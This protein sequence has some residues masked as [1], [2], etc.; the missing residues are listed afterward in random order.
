M[1]FGAFAAVAGVDVDHVK[2]FGVL[3]DEIGPVLVSDGA[4][5]GGLDLAGDREIVENGDIALVELDDVF[6]FGG[7]ECDVVAHFFVDFPVVDV[8]AFKRGIEE[9]AKQS[10]GAAGLFVNERRL[11]GGVAVLNLGHGSIPTREE[12]AQFLVELC[13]SPSFGYG[14]NDD[15]ETFGLDAVH[16]LL[17]TC[18]LGIAFDFSGDADLVGEGDEDEITTRKG[19]F[20]GDARSLGGNGFLD[21]LHQHFL[22]DLDG[23]LNVAVFFGVGLARYFMKGKGFAFPVLEQVKVMLKL[24]VAHA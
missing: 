20:A 7:N 2:G 6:R 14:A 17:E 18:S 21:D 8:D 24:S 4:T 9:V 23:V 16:E 12:D 15:A 3:N 5:E 19:D 11:V 1:P 22:A 13:H 10:H